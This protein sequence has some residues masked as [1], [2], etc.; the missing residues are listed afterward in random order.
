MEDVPGAPGGSVVLSSSEG[1]AQVGLGIS[2]R[3]LRCLSPAR[4]LT[5]LLGSSGELLPH[6]TRLLQSL[7][8][9]KSSALFSA[10]VIAWQQLDAQEQRIYQLQTRQRERQAEPQQKRSRIQQ[11]SPDPDTSRQLQEG[12]HA[13][14]AAPHL[15]ATG[16]PTSPWAPL[17]LSRFWPQAATEIQVAN[18]KER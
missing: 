1:H 12:P 5:V 17:V 6:E 4:S 16:C 2:V 18:S 9:D 10:A 7:L 11:L 8:S 13:E 3:C 15:A 14:C